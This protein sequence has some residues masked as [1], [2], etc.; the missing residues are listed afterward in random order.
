MGADV[1]ASFSF[2]SYFCI[3][4]RHLVVLLERG[5]SLRYFT[6][7]CYSPVGDERDFGSVF[8]A[9]A[10]TGR[11]RRRAHPSPLTLEL[12]IVLFSSILFP[13][14]FFESRL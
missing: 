3:S 11:P 12:A 9:R 6:P 14:F 13:K 4:L 7:S 5:I 10:L 8:K 1:C 2:L